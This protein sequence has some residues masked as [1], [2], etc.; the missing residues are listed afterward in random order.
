VIPGG[1]SKR[2]FEVAGLLAEGLT[3][4]QI[5]ER[6]T[7]VAQATIYR[8]IYN[9]KL[10]LGLPNRLALITWYREQPVEELSG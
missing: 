4:K 5:A 9:A 2:E 10:K 7:D 6:L 3:S 8:H 1:L